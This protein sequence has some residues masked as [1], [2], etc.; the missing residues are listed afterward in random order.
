MLADRTRFV[1]DQAAFA[2]IEARVLPKARR[3]TPGEFGTAVAKAVARYDRDAAAR[4]LKA[5]ETRRMTV[6]QLEDGL[7]HLGLV[8]DWAT[9]HAIATAVTADARRLHA[10]RTAASGSSSESGVAAAGST[11]GGTAGTRAA[12]A[13]GSAGA[14]VAV[15]D[16]VDE[17]GADACRADALAAR[18]LGTIDPRTGRCRWDRDR[19]QVSAQLVIDLPTLRHEAENPCLLDGQPVPAAIGRDLAGYARTWRRMITDPVT[20][21]LLDY[22][23]DTYLPAPLR[24]YVLARDGGCRAPGCTTKAPHRLQLD[25]ADPYPH[26]PSNT[27]N[28][29]GACTTCHQLKTAGHVGITDTAP[30]GSCTWR[31]GWGQAIRVPPRAYLDDPEPDPDPPPP[32]PPPEQTPPF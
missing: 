19:V 10:T 18:I 28:T 17:V 31:T 20:G 30:D 26:G 21:H 23:R 1:T 5:R 8:H 13:T 11:A 14:G 27:T 7:G 3:T 22:G 4:L 12:G 24:T 2:R 32:Q 29:G 15:A 25:H 6:R 9:I 16:G